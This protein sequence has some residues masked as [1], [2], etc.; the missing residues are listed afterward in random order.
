MELFVLIGFAAS[1]LFFMCCLVM[2]VAF[3]FGV[4]A[5]AEKLLL[6]GKRQTMI[7]SPVM[8]AFATLVGGVFVAGVYWAMHHS[9]LNPMVLPVYEAK[10]GE[11]GKI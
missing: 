2:H 5:D 9:T 11:A 8:W 6:F 3:A 4:F 1:A 7:V 10:R